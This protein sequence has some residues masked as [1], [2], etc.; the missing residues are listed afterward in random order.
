MCVCMRVCER[1]Y[2]LGK[3]MNVK[4]KS[5]NLGA[6]LFSLKQEGKSLVT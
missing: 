6:P 1:E 3:E 4:R 2:C 5:E